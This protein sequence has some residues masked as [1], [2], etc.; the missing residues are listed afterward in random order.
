MDAPMFDERF[1]IRDPKSHYM[2]AQK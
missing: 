1:A 2:D